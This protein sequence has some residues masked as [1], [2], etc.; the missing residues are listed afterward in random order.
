MNGIYVQLYMEKISVGYPKGI[1]SKSSIIS[2]II[3]VQL[4][5][6]NICKQSAKYGKHI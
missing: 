4:Y 5:M 1:V 3:Y 6:E 2:M